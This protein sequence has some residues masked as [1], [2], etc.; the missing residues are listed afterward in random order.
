M[1]TYYMFKNVS[2]YH[3]AVMIKISTVKKLFFSKLCPIKMKLSFLFW[4][5][6]ICIAV[7]GKFIPPFY[8]CDH[9]NDQVTFSTG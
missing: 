9:L 4:V 5:L 6:C 7:K 1:F 2:L 8:G 3:N